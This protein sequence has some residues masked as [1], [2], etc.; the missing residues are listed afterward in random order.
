MA[1]QQNPWAGLPVGFGDCDNVHV[2]NGPAD[3][4]SSWTEQGSVSPTCFAPFRKHLAEN[5]LGLPVRQSC[6][7]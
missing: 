6:A 2:L 7:F 1:G 4:I 5:S 3:I